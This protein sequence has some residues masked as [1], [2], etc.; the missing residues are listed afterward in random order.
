[1]IALDPQWQVADSVET[2]GQQTAPLGRQ[3]TSR[4][5]ST[6]GNCFV[7]R[8]TASLLSALYYPTNP[9]SLDFLVLDPSE[10]DDM[11]G[12]DHDVSV[13]TDALSSDLSLHYPLSSFL[14]ADGCFTPPILP[15]SPATSSHSQGPSLCSPLSDFSTSGSSWFHSDSIACGGAGQSFFDASGA[16]QQARDGASVVLA[17]EVDDVAAP[18]VSSTAVA[19]VE[20]RPTP[21]LVDRAARKRG[22]H[23]LVD[24][25]RRREEGLVLQR[26][27][28]LASLGGPQ[29]DGPP[30][31][32][33]R[34]PVRARKL[35][36]LRASAERLEELQRLCSSR[37]AGHDRAAA[38]AL[39]ISSASKRRLV[40]SSQKAASDE[41]ELA[42]FGTSAPSAST[43]SP[44]AS[45]LRDISAL[46]ARLTLRRSTVVRDPLNQVLIDVVTG[47]V[48]V[49]SHFQ[50]ATGWSPADML[51]RS[52]GTAQQGE[53]S[54]HTPDEMTAGHTKP[55]AMTGLPADA[56]RRWVRGRRPLQ[57]YPSAIQGRRELCMGLRQSWQDHWRVR[58]AD[59]HAYEINM[60]MTL[61]SYEEVRM[62][63]ASVRIRPLTVR[64]L[65]GYEAPVRLHDC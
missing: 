34:T 49:S 60:L 3:A 54:S 42:S 13:S 11:I 37:Q 17:V 62:H 10:V 47:R 28:Q 30:G 23:R 32:M 39:P 8:A 7:L 1:M 25:R 45:Y 46:D 52:A 59:G 55:L 5:T 12:C 29:V 27:A 53:S 24:E 4:S 50:R 64:I 38:D 57:Q 65:S 51:A 44:V 6:I 56:Q 41:D 36:V 18:V 48:V 14:L 22:T 63:D 35:A 16:W 26:L 58:F 33:A 43:D 61:H 21:T 31:K 15:L 20:A 2:F 19:S 40:D 9:T